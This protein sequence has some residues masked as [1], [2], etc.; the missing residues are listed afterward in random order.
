MTSV[1]PQLKIITGHIDTNGDILIDGGDGNRYDG[2]AVAESCPL[3][4]LGFKANYTAFTVW[5]DG[6]TPT[7]WACGVAPFVSMGQK[8]T[9]TDGTVVQKVPTSATL[10]NAHDNGDDVMGETLQTSVATSI[11]TA[12]AIRCT[13]MTPGTSDGLFFELVVSGS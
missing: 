13:T 5:A 4:N 6:D 11:V 2:S 12:V 8:V 10:I 1:E 3:I 7:A 9:L